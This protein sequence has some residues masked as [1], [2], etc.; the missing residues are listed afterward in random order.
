VHKNGLW[1]KGK[2]LYAMKWEICG[3]LEKKIHLTEVR[4]YKK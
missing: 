2:K 1:S 4:L 3:P